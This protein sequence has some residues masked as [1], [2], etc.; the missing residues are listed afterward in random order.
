MSDHLHS[1]EDKTT[2]GCVS[3][4]V[5]KHSTVVP[6]FHVHLIASDQLQNNSITATVWGV[7]WTVIIDWN[8]MDAILY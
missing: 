2:E 3:T 5:I 7:S 4:Q 8:L 1:E 6:Q